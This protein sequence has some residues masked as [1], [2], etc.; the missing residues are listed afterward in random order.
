MEG[1]CERCLFGYR[2]W[3]LLASFHPSHPALT[4]GIEGVVTSPT[5]DS[6]I[7]TRSLDG[8]ITCKAAYVSLSIVGSPFSWGKHILTWRIF[9]D[10]VPTDSA[11]H[12]R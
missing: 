6:L 7:W 10:K 4:Y 2:G 1:P 11:L 9:H 3:V 8:I 12:A 5:L